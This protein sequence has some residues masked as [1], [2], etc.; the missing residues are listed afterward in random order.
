MK[1][2]WAVSWSTSAALVERVNRGWFSGSLTAD[3]PRNANNSH[4]RLVILTHRSIPARVPRRDL[5]HVHLR[6]SSPQDLRHGGCAVGPP[7]RM[8]HRRSSTMGFTDA[9]P[10]LYRALRYDTTSARDGCVAQARIPSTG[11]GASPLEHLPD[12]SDSPVDRRAV[13]P[14]GTYPRTV[15]SPSTVMQLQIPGF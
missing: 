7:L 14:C 13:M 2:R 6:L 11:G 4:A 12:A 3:P 1:A 10:T 8:G 15:A 5:S 9:Y